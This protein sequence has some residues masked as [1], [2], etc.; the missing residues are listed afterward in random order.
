M[1][2]AVLLLETQR[3]QNLPAV[4]H[5]LASAKKEILPDDTLK[6]VM[7]P[8]L[9][10]A[11]KREMIQ[12]HERQSLYMIRTWLGIQEFCQN[13]SDLEVKLYSIVNRTDITEM[14]FSSR[15]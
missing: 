15:E 13:V 9:L 12:R 5:V 11:I 10:H 14:W 7:D 8:R 1:R 6:N 4:E 2:K 3:R